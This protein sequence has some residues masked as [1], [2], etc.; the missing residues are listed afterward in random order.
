MLQ[1]REARQ[2]A[3][4]LLEA[5][6]EA[7]IRHKRDIAL[8]VAAERERWADAM[9]AV[10]CSDV[11]TQVRH[12]LEDGQGTDTPDGR[13]WLDALRMLNTGPNAAHQR[14]PTAQAPQTE[15]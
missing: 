15:E 2:E 7:A 5:A 3:Q 6:Q 11:G 4:R 14:N 13:A 8:A 10:M 1:E 12:K 9:R